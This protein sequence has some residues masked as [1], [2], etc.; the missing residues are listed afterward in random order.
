MDG[1]SVIIYQERGVWPSEQKQKLSFMLKKILK[2][3]SRLGD[4]AD[5]ELRVGGGPD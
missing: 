3:N 4:S 2:I 5:N 1:P